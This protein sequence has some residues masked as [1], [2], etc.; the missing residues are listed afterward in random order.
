MV[1]SQPVGEIGIVWGAYGVWSGL[2]MSPDGDYCLV[3]VS[4]D[5]VVVA[6]EY[7]GPIANP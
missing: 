7:V 5:D 6:T 1:G 3:A 2:G 4:F